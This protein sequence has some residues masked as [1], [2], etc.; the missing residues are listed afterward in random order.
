MVTIICNYTFMEK[1]LGSS[2]SIP[3]EN[4]KKYISIQ[5]KE[6]KNFK[7]IFIFSLMMH[8]YMHRY[9]RKK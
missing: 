3:F 2:G 7:N 1:S 8:T 5:P 9:E 6:K 4:Y